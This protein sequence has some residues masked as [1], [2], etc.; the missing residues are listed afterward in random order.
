[1][2]AKDFKE[3]TSAQLDI[4]DAAALTATKKSLQVLMSAFNVSAGAIPRPDRYTLQ[5]YLQHFKGLATEQPNLSIQN[6]A[7]AAITYLE[8]IYAQRLSCFAYFLA[9]QGIIIKSIEVD[10]EKFK[11]DMRRMRPWGNNIYSYGNYAPYGQLNI[12]V[13]STRKASTKASSE[14]PLELIQHLEDFPTMEESVLEVLRILM[15]GPKSRRAEN[16]TDAL[17]NA[18]GIMQ[19]NK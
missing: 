15:L 7:Y 18:W 8:T 6:T 14:L 13:G 2:L 5:T 12:D 10:Y 11:I 4:E 17:I 9:T 3:L 16:V 1:M 19:K